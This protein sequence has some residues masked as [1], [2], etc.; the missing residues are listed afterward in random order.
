MSTPARKVS[1]ARRGYFTYA[2]AEFNAPLFFLIAAI[3]LAAVI[4]SAL[5]RSIE[6][7]L[8][9][10]MVLAIP[11]AAVFIHLAWQDRQRGIRRFL[12]YSIFVWPTVSLMQGA[13]FYSLIVALK[14][15]GVWL[16]HNV[17]FTTSSVIAMTLLTATIGSLL[18]WF[19][20]RY[21]CL[22]GSTEASVGLLIAGYKYL[23]T[24]A[25]YTIPSDPNFYLVVLTAGIYLV[26]RGLDNIHQGLYGTPGDPIAHKFRNWYLT[27]GTHT[28]SDSN[29]EKPLSK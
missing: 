26:V 11:F 2:G 6:E 23:G 15:S 1:S 14:D 24:G 7:Y 5:N 27:F 17:T 10:S 22:Y 13:W 3:S 12:F 9:Y 18:F 19:R 16:F 4:Y 8:R 29:G 25:A 20:L 21:R 28:E